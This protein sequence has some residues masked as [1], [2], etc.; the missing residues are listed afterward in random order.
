MSCTKDLA[1]LSLSLGA[2]FAERGGQ[3]VA[4]RLT[5]GQFVTALQINDVIKVIQ[6]IVTALGDTVLFY[7]LLH[8]SSSISVPLGDC[9][10]WKRSGMSH[11]VECKYVIKSRTGDRRGVRIGDL[12]AVTGDRGLRSF[13]FSVIGM[14]SMTPLRLWL[15]P[16]ILL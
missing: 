12:L 14:Q 6:L 16:L 4:I 1:N 11:L 8:C 10:T 7:S 9:L 15:I 2:E 5:P 3:V 13:T